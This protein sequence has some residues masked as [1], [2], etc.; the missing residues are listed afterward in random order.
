MIMNQNITVTNFAFI[1]KQK[2]IYVFNDYSSNKLTVISVVSVDQTCSNTINGVGA[3]MIT[4]QALSEVGIQSQKKN[5][6][7][8]WYFIS[9][10]YFLLLLFIF[11]AIGVIILGY[12][13]KQNNISLFGGKSKKV[14]TIYYDN[15][16][17]IKEEERK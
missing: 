7:P 16:S 6:D 14:N 12:N 9:L 17:R 4:E 1:F 8:D 15:I 11:G 3:S 5:V 10:A 13:L 2:G